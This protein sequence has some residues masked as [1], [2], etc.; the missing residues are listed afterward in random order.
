MVQRKMYVKEVDPNKAESEIEL[1]TIAAGYGFSPKI[2]EVEYYDDTCKITM[3]HMEAECLANIYGDDPEDIPPWIWDQIRTMVTTLYEHE[4]IEYVDITPYNFIEKDNRIYMIDFGDA[5]YT[6][7]NK[8]ADW[9][10]RE[11]MDG[12][13]SWNPDYK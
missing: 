6:D 11:F 5:R 4:G 1:Q 3:A 13:N 12:E 2:S 9:F 8:P 10:L 7:N